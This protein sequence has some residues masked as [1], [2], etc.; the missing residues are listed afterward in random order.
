M[1]KLG[2][3]ALKELG[4]S[5]KVLD[6]EH[7]NRLKG[8][9]GSDYPY[10]CP[11]E[12]I[13]SAEGPGHIGTLGELQQL[14]KGYNSSANWFGGGSLIVGL[15]SSVNIGGAFGGAYG[16]STGSY[17]FFQD[18]VA[19]RI[20]VEVDKLQDMGYSSSSK[21]RIEYLDSY[22]PGV[23]EGGT[24]RVKVWDAETGKLLSEITI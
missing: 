17:G 21:L 11:G 15:A 14:Q 2:K 24:Y 4:E 13:V 9:D 10:Y 22:F 12:V 5:V 18:N 8:G 6:P 7:V 23:C 1:K 19:D 3:L 20:G 16:L